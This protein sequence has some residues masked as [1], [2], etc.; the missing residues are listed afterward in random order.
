MVKSISVT[1]LKQTLDRE[2]DTWLVDV[3][4]VEEYERLHAPAVKR[5]IVHTEIASSLHLLPADKTTPLYLICRSGN[6]S[7]KAARILAELGFTEA[8][9]VA[10]GMMAWLESGFP[11][12]TGRGVLDSRE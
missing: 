4:T 8:T 7:G 6:R 5:V 12:D 1:D 3:R 2:P 11:A 9:N 10:G